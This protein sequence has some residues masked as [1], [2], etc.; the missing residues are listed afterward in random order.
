MIR[1]IVVCTLASDVTEIGVELDNLN[2]PSVNLRLESPA[3]TTL[4]TSLIPSPVPH[5]PSL[6]GYVAS[7]VGTNTCCVT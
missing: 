7:D 6:P 5:V 1:G 3:E 4:R 2:V